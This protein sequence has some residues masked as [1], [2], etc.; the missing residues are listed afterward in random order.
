MIKNLLLFLILIFYLSLNA[1]TFNWA[2][3]HPISI[4]T[5]PAYLRNTVETDTSGNVIYSRLINN[6][7]LYSQTYLGDN[8]IIKRNSEGNILWAYTIFGKADISGLYADR[9]NNIICAGKFKDTLIVNQHYTFYSSESSPVN[10]IFKIDE[11]GNILWAKN[12]YQGP[13]DFSLVTSVTTDALNNIWLT[14]D[15]FSNSAI[16]KY[17]PDGNFLSSIIQTNVRELSD[18]SI[19]Q[20][21][22]IFAVGAAFGFANQSFNG[23][24]IIPPFSYNK[25]IVKYS[26]SGAPQWVRF[27]E[28]I[29]FPESRIV[30][31]NEGNAYWSGNLMDST[32]FGNFF[33]QGPQW[34]YDYFLTKIDQDGN[35]I[36]LRE[37]PSGNNTG[38]ATIGTADFLC[39]GENGYLYLSGF[40][41]GTINFGN[42]VIIN[43]SGNSDAMVLKYSSDGNI[44]WG[45]N[46][47]GNWINEASAVTADKSGNCYVSGKIGANSSFGNIHPGGGDLNLFLAKITDNETVPVELVSFTGNYKNN[48]VVLNWATSS[49]TNNSG[50]EIERLKKPGL[51]PGNNEWDKI[52][53]V[54]GRGTTTE[55]NNY[56]F[57]DQYLQTGIYQYRL[58]QIDLN[59]SFRFSSIV[60]IEVGVLYQFSLSQNYPNPFNP[61]TKI[62]FTVPVTSFVNLNI[63]DVTG[64]E[65]STLINEEKKP[66]SYEIDFPDKSE[67]LLN[68]ASGLYFYRLKAGSFVETKKMLLLK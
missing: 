30:T 50:F 59:G 11:N 24:N 21:G 13:Q 18:I 7:Q 20:N 16:L 56:S 14:R 38:D 31:D 63:Y 62:K 10:F 46:A 64:K 37:I 25:Y 17:D 12:L 8:E 19:D 15:D 5:N 52:G 49:E 6:K 26:S 9:M 42:G 54:N 23:L 2:Y 57:T 58:K 4:T 47:A 40:L 66:G 45:I 29:T 27:V 35:F 39:F 48:N 22:N 34:V 51:L 61:V 33:A 28:D 53:F 1:Q 60:E 65:I 67:D 44:V 41:R 43:T 32:H 36:W 3:T 55:L 68:L